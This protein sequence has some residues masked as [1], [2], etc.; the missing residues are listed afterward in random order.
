MVPFL[1][2][3]S[4]YLF[5][6]TDIPLDST[7]LEQKPTGVQGIEKCLPIGKTRNFISLSLSVHNGTSALSALLECALS[8]L[9]LLLL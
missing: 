1:S 5:S 9:L 3:I 7:N 6:H 2:E 4:I 8:L